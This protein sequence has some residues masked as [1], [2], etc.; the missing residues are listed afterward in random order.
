MTKVIDNKH[1]TK[2]KLN[3]KQQ[4]YKGIPL[5]LI[6]RKYGTAKARR[7][8]LNGS[9][10]NVWVPLKHLEPDCTIK[11]GEDIDYVFF[12]AK[13]QCELAGIK[14]KFVIEERWLNNV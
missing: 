13:R 14:I 4:D 6:N 12:Q 10:Q 7:F 9:N 2:I 11:E 5:Q 3:Y 1:S 8:T